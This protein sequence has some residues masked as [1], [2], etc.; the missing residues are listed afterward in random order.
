RTSGHTPGAQFDVDVKN[1]GDGGMLVR[2]GR[3]ERGLD[4]NVSF[5]GRHRLFRQVDVDPLLA[6]DGRDVRWRLGRSLLRDR[7]TEDGGA[8]GAGD[9]QPLTFDYAIRIANFIGLHQRGDAHVEANLNAGQCV[10]V[11]H[12]VG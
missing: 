4:G 5:H 11:S 3:D 1:A 10:A 8:A 12:E 6:R 7:G 2:A 9:G